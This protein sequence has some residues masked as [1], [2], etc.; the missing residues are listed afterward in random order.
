MFLANVTLWNTEFE[1]NVADFRGGAIYQ[2]YGATLYG[3]DCAF[4]GNEANGF[5]GAIFSEDRNSQTVGTFPRFIDTTFESNDA[6]IDGGAIYWY[7]GVI[8]TLENCQFTSNIAQNKGGAIALVNS[9][10]SI[11]TNPIYTSNEAKI[12]STT[13]SVYNEPDYQY[14]TIDDSLIFNLTHEITE[15]YNKSTEMNLINDP[16][17]P[18]IIGTD[19]YP[20][21][22]TSTLC[23]VDADNGSPLSQDGNSWDT[24]YNELQ[25]CLD[26][27]HTESD[28]GEVWV[29]SGIYIP[30]SVPEWKIRVGKTTGIHQSFSLYDNIRLYGGF[31]GGETQRDQRNFAKNP[32][33]LSCQINKRVQCNQIM[34][35]ADNTLIDGFI[36]INA[37]QGADQRRRLANSLTLQ[38]VLQSTSGAL[39]SGIYSNSTNIIVM[40]T[41]FYKLLA[42]GKGGGVYCIGQQGD[43]VNNVKSPTFVNVAFLGNRAGARGG[44]I[45]ADGQCNF[46][47]KYCRFDSNECSKKG[48]AIYLDFDSDIDIIDTTFENNLALESGGCIAAD[49]KSV[50]TFKN[51]IQFISNKA[52]MEGGC[53]YSG[54]GVGPNIG[55]GF[56]FN[57]HIPLF[58]NNSITNM[59]QAGQEDIYG[60]PYSLINVTLSDR[61]TTTTKPTISP[62]PAPVTLLNHDDIQP[63][64]I[65]F[66]IDDILF[67]ADWAESAP[68]GTELDGKTITYNDFPTVNIA[69]FMKESI[70]FPQ[71]YVAGPKC[72]PSRFAVLTGRQTSRAEWAIHRTLQTCS[73][74]LGVNVTIQTSKI[75]LGD[76]TNNIP[77]ILQND[78]IT[79]YYT[80]MVGKWHVMG[81]N[82]NIYDCGRL[83]GTQNETLYN[84]CKDIVTN[85]GFDFVDAWYYS[86]IGENDYF[87]HNP[88]WLVSQSQ[89]FIRQAQNKN[90]P[91]FLYFAST[92]AHSPSSETSLTQFTRADSP[93]GKLTTDKPDDTTM[94]PR[95]AILAKAQQLAGSDSNKLEFMAQALWTDEQFGALINYLKE[96]D[97]YDETMVVLINDHGMGAKGIL[98]QQGSRIINYVRYP[99][100]FGD[101]GPYV[102]P[103]DF[104]V[105]TVDLSAVIFEITRVNPPSNYVSDGISWIYDVQQEILA[106]SQSQTHPQTCCK[107]RYLD[108]KNS[109]SI[110]T[111]DYQ[112][113]Y[114][115]NPNQV[116]RDNDVD[117]LYPFMY[118]EEQLYNL[119][120]DPNQQNNQ[121]DNYELKSLINEFQSLMQDYLYDICPLPDKSRCKKPKL[122]WTDSPTAQPTKS[123]IDPYCR[124]AHGNIIDYRYVWINIDSYRKSQDPQYQADGLTEFFNEGGCPVSNEIN[125]Y[126][127]NVDYK[128]AAN[129]VII[130]LII[131]CDDKMFPLS[132]INSVNPD[133]YEFVDLLSDTKNDDDFDWLNF[134]EYDPTKQ[135]IAISILS[136]IVCCCIMVGLYFYKKEKFHQFKKNM[137]DMIADKISIPS[138]A[139]HEKAPTLVHLPCSTRQIDRRMTVESV[140]KSSTLYTNATPTPITMV[141]VTTMTSSASDGQIPMTMLPV[142]TTLNTSASEGQVQLTMIPITK[143]NTSV[144]DGAIQLETVQ[145]S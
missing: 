106:Q 103:S 56:Q 40:N 97:I 4:N 35:S 79:P 67:T 6:G 96:K 41:I 78:P 59:N 55:Q 17:I 121:I 83:E 137:T 63:N 136:I 10:E 18:L 130:D 19:S 120:D 24:A 26:K 93:K 8:G 117:Q 44:A 127:Y 9:L 143:M 135:A 101:N 43:D 141:P 29:K 13:N 30:N 15:L 68:P 37:G 54:S 80:G 66:V 132:Y 3:N 38:L 27:L 25:D 128:K 72:S 36:F 84:L 109:H 14:E 123:P 119:N 23:F 104:I 145:E 131:C 88:E 92:L 5:G 89:K 70:I 32:T 28:G 142:T 62:T 77:Y 122:S 74:E 82:E 7:N 118:A 12:D 65:I 113:I 47:C 33:Y 110:V 125:Q 95:A 73:G 144:S 126:F 124:S 39:G 2:D 58:I 100:L 111:G 61:D 140:S 90:K 76:N 64:I 20:F 105:S 46:K 16:D 52:E 69:N 138:A 34:I 22:E 116:E 42:A 85:Q 129:R 11:I 51:D 133:E 87:G 60:W 81:S 21:D 91:F 1:S 98:Y 108:I 50:V 139:K 115:A 86:N 48:G 112:Y 45:S 49:G 107:H 71:S 114:R 31:A 102:M 53:L 75:T 94:S 57:G 99:P 134:E